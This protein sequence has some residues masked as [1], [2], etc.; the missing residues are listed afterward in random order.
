MAEEAAQDDDEIFVYMGGNQQV[1]EHIR[2]AKIHISVKIIRENV[3]FKC[4]HLIYVEFHDGVEIIE[5]W[6]FYRCPLRG[7]IKLLGVKIVQNYA[8]NGC[9]LTDV[10]FGDKLETIEHQAFEYCT[11]L[12]SIK[13]KSVRTI[14]ATAF[15]DCYELTDLEFG[16]N[17]ETIEEYAFCNCPKLKRITLSLKD[18][19]KWD[20]MSFLDVIITIGADSF[21]RCPKLETVDLIGGIHQTVASLHLENWRSEM[22]N[23]INRI[24]Q[25]LPTLEIGRKTPEIQQWMRS[26]I[27][28]LN[29]YKAEHHKIL[30]EATTLLELALWK[31]NLDDNE[32]DRH[33]REGIRRVGDLESSR[34]EIR[35]TS[36]ASIVIKNV[37]SF[38][39]LK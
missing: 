18:T 23:E 28:R 9:P 32:G 17:L 14:G 20:Y 35:Y 37:L 39:A 21:H 22:N 15:G 29:R 2:R 10:E 16:Q 3:F 5:E 8:F 38:L 33:K 34:D 30:K 27:C 4:K 26:T 6:A 31:A 12:K 7:R 24:N 36:G 11:R 1:P 19:L 25:T 13:M